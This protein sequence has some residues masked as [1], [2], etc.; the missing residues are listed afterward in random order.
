MYAKPASRTARATRSS[1]CP[2][3]SPSNGRSSANRR[4]RRD[5]RTAAPTRPRRS[6]PGRV[7]APLS[8]AEA[9]RGLNWSTGRPA[10]TPI[11]HARWGTRGASSSGH[12]PVGAR[13]PGSR[14]D[15]SARASESVRLRTPSGIRVSAETP[16]PVLAR[17][18]S[19][20][21]RTPPRF[22]GNASGAIREAPSS[23]LVAVS[24]SPARS[25][26]AAARSIRRGTQSSS[27]TI[28]DQMRS[29]DRTRPSEAQASSSASSGS[30]RPA[31]LATDGAFSRAE[32]KGGSGS[33]S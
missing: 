16:R 10:R 23:R 11:G 31:V 33:T 14:C 9:A 18:G 24:T 29:V 13:C 12:Q 4:S 7:L 17:S 19:S 25:S 3:R 27:R 20:N 8:S 6:R 32:S 28:P 21:P 2:G 5:R 22:T 30:P 15:A 1:S 26:V